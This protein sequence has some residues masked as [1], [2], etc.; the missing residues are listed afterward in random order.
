MAPQSPTKPTI[1]ENIL[2]VLN[3]ASEKTAID[4]PTKTPL[5]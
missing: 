2:T 3:K 4:I 5:Q 1:K